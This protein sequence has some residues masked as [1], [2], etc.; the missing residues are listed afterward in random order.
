ML[1]MSRGLYT[2]GKFKQNIKKKRRHIGDLIYDHDLA[3]ERFCAN[4]YVIKIYYAITV[5]RTYTFTF[6]KC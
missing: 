4:L 2:D 3:N 5:C 6:R 1:K